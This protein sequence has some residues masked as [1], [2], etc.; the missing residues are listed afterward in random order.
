MSLWSFG[1]VREVESRGYGNGLVRQLN[2]EI[3]RRPLLDAHFDA[4]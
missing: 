4:L 3:K 2:G 1:S